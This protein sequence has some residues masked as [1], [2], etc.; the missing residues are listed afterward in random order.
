MRGYQGKAERRCM[1]A[2]VDEFRD[3]QDG[4]VCICTMQSKKENEL[5]WP[6]ASQRGDL[7]IIMLN[8]CVKPSQY[9]RASAV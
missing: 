3:E 4:V 1:F 2:Y 8:L 7:K 6:V 5:R 9:I